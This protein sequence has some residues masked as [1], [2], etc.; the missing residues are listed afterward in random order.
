M[1]TVS[2]L[3]II[4]FTIFTTSQLGIY[5]VA[6]G[7]LIGAAFQFLIQYPQFK[8][9]NIKL[10]FSFRKHLVKLKS[11]FVLLFP[12][13]VTSLGAQLNEVINRVV[14]SG[15]PEGSIS[16]LNYSNKLMYLPLSVIAMSIITVL[17]P[18]IVEAFKVNKD[19]FTTLC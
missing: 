18:S 9:Y 17:Y 8:Q 11:S 5:G 1:I 14:A 2:N 16:A 15:L 13:V 3:I 12:V 6:I 10:N 7:T 4:V 19:K